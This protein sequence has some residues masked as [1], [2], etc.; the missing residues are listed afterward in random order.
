[1][2]L[3]WFVAKLETYPSLNLVNDYFSF[4]KQRTKIGS[5][6]TEWANVTKYSSGIYVWPLHVN[7]FINDIFLFIEK[8]DMCNF[9]EDNTLFSDED[10]LS[11]F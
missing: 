4:R 7:I 8:S 1:M 9:A 10:N 3:K 6:Y 2:A 11:V 5:S